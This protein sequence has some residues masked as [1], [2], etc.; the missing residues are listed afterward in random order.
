LHLECDLIE[1]TLARLWTTE[2]MVPILFSRFTEKVDP[3]PSCDFTNNPIS[4]SQ[5]RYLANDL[6]K[7]SPIPVPDLLTC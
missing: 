5:V 6:H 1:K 2:S 4:P 7:K 3:S